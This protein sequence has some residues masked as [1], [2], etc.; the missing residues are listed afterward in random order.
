MSAATGAHAAATWDDPEKITWY[1][2]RQDHLWP[3]AE[4]ESLLVS[5]VPPS[6]TRLLDLGCGDGR[7]AALV[8]EARPSLTEVVA[9]DRSA[10][11]LERAAERFRGDGRVVLRE[12]DLADP[13]G[14]LGSFDV[15]VSG[16]AIHHLE[17]DRKRSLFAEVAQRLRAGESSPTSRSWRRRPRSSTS[18]SSPRSGARRTTRRTGW[19]EPRSRPSGCAGQVSSGCAAC[20]GGG[21]SRSSSARLRRIRPP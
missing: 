5:V 15:V 13:L 16:L 19:P 14:P 20:G 7:L 18:A 4:A 6:P 10:A 3:R 12:R 1:L 21:P 11:M 9:I 17:H 8:L 2:E